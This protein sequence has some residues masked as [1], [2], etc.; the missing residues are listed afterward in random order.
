MRINLLIVILLG[1]LSLLLG[2]CTV[3]DSILDGKKCSKRVEKA[4]D[5]DYNCVCNANDVCTCQ[6][7]TTSAL[8]QSLTENQQQDKENQDK[9][10]YQ[11]PNANQDLAESEAVQLEESANSVE[12]MP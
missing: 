2:S 12:E 7:K 9:D 6:K 4:C 11:D 5:S 1:T 10:K 8:T 3:D